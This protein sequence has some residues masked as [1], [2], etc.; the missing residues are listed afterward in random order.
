MRW[1]AA[2]LFVAVLGAQERPE[3]PLYSPYFGGR[4]NFSQEDLARIARSFDFVYGQSPSKAEME[5]ARKF[6]A[7]TQFIRY[8]GAWT[9]TAQN[10]EK[11]LRLEILYH[12][13]AALGASIDARATAF[14]LDA[15]AQYTPLQLK[16]STTAGQFSK[17]V[18]EA[19]TWLRIG[20]EMMRIESFDEGSRQ[21]R[22]TRAFDGGTAQAHTKGER[23]FSPDYGMPPGGMHDPQI[24]KSLSYHY[25]AGAKARWNLILETLLRFVE[26]GGD[27]IWIDILADRSLNERD[28]MGRD[29]NAPAWNFAAGRAYTRDELREKNEAGV[30]FIQE[31]FRRKFGRYPVIYGNN[32]S[33]A[34]YEEGTGGQKFYLLPTTVKPRPVDGMCIEDFMG[35]YDQTEWDLWTKDKTVSVPRKACYPCDARYKNWAENMKEL[36]KTSQGNMAAI[37]LMINAGMK[38]AIFER[39]DR[40]RRHEWERWAYASYLLAVEKKNGKCYT[41]L[42]VPM[43]YYEG[44]RR[45]VDLDPM[46]YWKIGA[47]AE[48]VNPA[49][50]ERYRIAGS[51]VFRRKFENG[52]VLVNPGAKRETV[53][54]EKRY[55]DPDT[56]ASID[57]VAMEP[58]SGK[59]LLGK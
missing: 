20:D 12:Q 35:G 41:K 14:P 26:E 18:Q 15:I 48:T 3:Y 8:V 23:V 55:V 49:D 30:R 21:V 11:S 56:G 17:S 28:V 47:P 57:S 52:L 36:M 7:G 16:P 50:L 19:V 29:W 46:Y 9:V 25:D 2:L 39:L 24:S 22:V 27:G 59:I 4:H 32:M 58:A 37:P 43:F 34:R 45:F 5:Q 42:G 40:T 6:H 10:A 44:E 33:A 31:E 51:S 13:V 1:I 53:K 54:L 38:T